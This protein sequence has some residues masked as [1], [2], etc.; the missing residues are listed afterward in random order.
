MTQ[1]HKLEALGIDRRKILKYIFKK[2]EWRTWTGLI[3]L[4]DTEKICLYCES[5]NIQCDSKKMRR[6]SFLKKD[7]VH[8]I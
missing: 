6:I 8:R 4:K 3:W 7:S 2:K 1:R 5:D